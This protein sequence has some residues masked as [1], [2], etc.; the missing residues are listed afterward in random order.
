MRTSLRTLHRAALALALAALPGA[1][2]AQAGG[3]T[4]AGKV[5]V[6]PAKYQAETVV[7][8]VKAP[9]TFEPK[10]VH[11]DQ[12]ALTFLPHVLVVTKGDTVTFLN[13][14]N[15]AHNVYSPDG[16]PYN[17]GTFKA[18]EERTHTFDETGPYSQLCSIH[19]EMLAY[20]YVTQ[21]PYAAAVDAK[22]HYA[23]KGVPAGTYQLGLWNS[24]LKGAPKTVTVSAGKTV[25]VDFELKR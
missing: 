13:H 1:A 17:L 21:N 19:P 12:K 6:T 23:I 15:V 8:V 4:I 22:G 20:V 7:Y 2:L 24:H 16:T 5:E 10:K 3:G 18:N 14:D 25:E 11:L 9:G